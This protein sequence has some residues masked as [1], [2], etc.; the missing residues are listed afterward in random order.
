MEDD[1][2]AEEAFDNTGEAFQQDVES[3]YDDKESDE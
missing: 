3:L 1:S 2:Y